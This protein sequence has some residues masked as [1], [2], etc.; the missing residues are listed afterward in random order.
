MVTAAV[1]M[2]TLSL[3]KSSNLRANLAAGPNRVAGQFPAPERIKRHVLPLASDEDIFTRRQSA[4]PEG[5]GG[6]WG[7][8][9]TRHPKRE[10]LW[11]R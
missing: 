1:L 9:A 3:R 4:T 10:T 11:Q 8:I 5:R 6:R 7:G 2:G